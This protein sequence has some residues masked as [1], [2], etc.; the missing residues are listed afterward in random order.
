M[1][2]YPDKTTDY[3]KISKTGT[4]EK[5]ALDLNIN[6]ASAE[7]VILIIIMGI[8]LTITF[9]KIHRKSYPLVKNRGKG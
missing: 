4:S 5:G 8:S 1:V 2:I 7:R 9:C 3:Q 6:G